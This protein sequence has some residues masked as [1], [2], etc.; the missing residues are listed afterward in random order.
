MARYRGKIITTVLGA[1][2]VALLLV[3]L[4][5]WTEFSALWHPRSDVE[6]IQG[7][8]TIL[9]ISDNGRVVPGSGRFV[10]DAESVELHFQN[11]ISRFAYTMDSAQQP[12]HFDIISSPGQSRLGIYAFEGNTLKICVNER[13]GGER[14]TA[15]ESTRGTPNDLLFVLQRK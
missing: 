2:V 9:Q 8:W 10:F 7:N 6:R 15:F 11:E 1:V 13:I 5:F 12:G 4:S 14:A 3:G